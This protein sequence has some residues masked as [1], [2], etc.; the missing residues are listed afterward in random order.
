MREQD[1]REEVPLFVQT[2][3]ALTIAPDLSGSRPHLLYID[4]LE[5]DIER[6]RHRLKSV[7][8]LH[9]V[10]E[11]WIGNDGLPILTECAPLFERT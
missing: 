9:T 10:H 8:V 2:P 4:L 1:R 6:R 3:V 7:V 11:Q 5:T